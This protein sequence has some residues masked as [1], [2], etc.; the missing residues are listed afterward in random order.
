MNIWKNQ[1]PVPDTL[2]RQVYLHHPALL[3]TDRKI[4]LV[5]GQKEIYRLESLPEIFSYGIGSW[6]HGYIPFGGNFNYNIGVGIRFTIPFWGGSDHKTK[7]HQSELRIQQMAEEKSQV[8]MDMKQEIDIS[9]NEISTLKNDIENQEKIAR[10]A[11]ETLNNAYVKYQAGQGPIID[12]LDA[13]SI[14]TEAA[15]AQRKSML[16]YLQAIARLHYITGNDNYPF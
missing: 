13:Q 5:A 15:I 10:L 7:M 3:E 11:Q 12:V 1:V 14:F 2:Y 8:F 4:S 16:A 6:E 9:L